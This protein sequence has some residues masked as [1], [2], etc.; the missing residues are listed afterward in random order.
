M[1]IKELLLLINAPNRLLLRSL[2]IKFVKKLRLGLQQ[3]HE[4]RAILNT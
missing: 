3:K 4:P 2:L 1:G